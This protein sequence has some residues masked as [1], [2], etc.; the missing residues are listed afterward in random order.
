[1]VECPVFEFLVWEFPKTSIHQV[2][3]TL[4]IGIILLINMARKGMLVRYY[5]NMHFVD[6]NISAMCVYHPKFAETDFHR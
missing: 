3:S 4:G 6:H 2:Y 5:K 1:M